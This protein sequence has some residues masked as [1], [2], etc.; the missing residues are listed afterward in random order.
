M[1]SMVSL[2]LGIAMVP[3]IVLDN[4]PLKDKVQIVSDAEQTIAGFEI[5]LAV[6]NKERH[7]PAL[8]AIW[9]IAQS[10]TQQAI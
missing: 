4:S 3:K 6:L 1:V 7:D 8:N 5:G 10:L 2:G 9:S